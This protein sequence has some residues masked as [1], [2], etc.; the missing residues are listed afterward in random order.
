[1]MTGAELQSRREALGLT[2][3]QL[4]DALGVT[5]VT[6]M[7]WETGKMEISLPRMVS[8]ALEALERRPHCGS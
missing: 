2:Q 6:I 4:A 7:R 5:Q 3:N 1:M 8:L